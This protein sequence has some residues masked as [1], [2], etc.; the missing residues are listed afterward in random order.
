MDKPQPSPANATPEE[1]DAY[2]QSLL[3]VVNADYQKQ[4]A[5]KPAPKHFISKRWLIFLVVS[6]VLSV[7]A[8]WA[9]SLGGKH[10][11]SSSSQVIKGVKTFNDPNA[12]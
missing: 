7:V 1:R 3:R 8:Y 11:N 2:A 12:Y 5:E 4:L 9:V 10:A 6:T